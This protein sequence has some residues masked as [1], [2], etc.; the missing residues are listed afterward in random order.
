MTVVFRTRQ[1][2][3]YAASEAKKQ[4]AWAL[5]NNRRNLLDISIQKNKNLIRSFIDGAEA[6]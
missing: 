2:D 3:W 1:S 4:L 5:K 6:A